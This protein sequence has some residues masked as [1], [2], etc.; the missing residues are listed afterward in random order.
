MSMRTKVINRLCGYFINDDSDTSNP[1]IYKISDEN[2]ENFVNN[3]YV[4]HLVNKEL[5]ESEYTQLRQ[6]KPRGGVKYYRMING[7]WEIV[8]KQINNFNQDYMNVP[9]DIISKLSKKIECMNKIFAEKDRLDINSFIDEESGVIN[10]FTPKNLDIDHKVP[11]QKTR[12]NGK[13]MTYNTYATQENYS[14][15]RI[16]DITDSE[17]SDCTKEFG[18]KSGK[19]SYLKHVFH[20]TNLFIE[21]NKYTEYNSFPLKR[22]LI[23]L[24]LRNLNNIYGQELKLISYFEK[25]EPQS[26]NQKKNHLTS[27]HQKIKK[28]CSD[29]EH[30]IYES[31]ADCKE[32]YASTWSRISSILTHPE[33]GSRYVQYLTNKTIRPEGIIEIAEKEI[34]MIRD[35]KY[36]REINERLRDTTVEQAKGVQGMFTCPKCR[37]DKTTYYQ[38]QT[39]SADEPMTV[40]I[41]CTS[42]Q[43]R[44]RMS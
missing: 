8:Y 43:H 27:T 35:H 4:Q 38:M 41:T 29:I 15:L 24:I 23:N 14:K 22:I 37:K 42:C 11:V 10:Y 39:R 28:L 17:F 25:C 12:L 2:K 32:K 9:E 7:I 30:Y 26:T 3:E 36:S 13:I 6:L 1:I 33:I 5:N 20:Y 31:S 18:I 21:L 16:R 19:Y 44:W 40:F 34:S